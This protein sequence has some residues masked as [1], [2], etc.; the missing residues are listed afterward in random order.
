MTRT[1]HTRLAFQFD[2]E[3]DDVPAEAAAA[4]ARMVRALVQHGDEHNGRPATMR[5]AL[6]GPLLNLWLTDPECS[7]AC[8]C[9]SGQLPSTAYQGCRPPRDVRL[10]LDPGPDDGLRLHWAMVVAGET[11]TGSAVPTQRQ[12]DRNRKPTRS[13][14]RTDERTGKR[15][16][17]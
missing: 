5:L 6:L 13:H 15:S 9:G 14:R 16:E 2:V 12:D 17:K 11:V 3:L 4:L 7:P 1:T 10:A 8:L